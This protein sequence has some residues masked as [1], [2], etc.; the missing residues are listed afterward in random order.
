MDDFNYDS[1]APFFVLVV[2]GFRYLMRNIDS[3]DETYVDT[4][5]ERIIN[6][7]PPDAVVEFDEARDIDF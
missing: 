3:E 5:C 1:D 2:N 4:Y 7:Y 6:S